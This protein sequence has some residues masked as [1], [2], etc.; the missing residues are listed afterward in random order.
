MIG[1]P[2]IYRWLIV[3][4]IVFGA[5]FYA[6]HLMMNAQPESLSALPVYGVQG[7]DQKDHTIKAF[8]LT[9]QFNN[10]VS[11]KDF[12]NKIYVADFIF[13]TCEGICPK[14][15]DQ[16]ERVYENFKGEQDVMFLSH[17]VKPEEDSIPVLKAYADM[18]H[19]TNDQWRFV[20]GDKKVIYDLA[21]S[22]YLV[23]DS[24]GAG[25]KDDFVHTQFF[26]LIDT[27][28]RIR[29]FYDGTDSVEVNK[30]I[31]DIDLLMNGR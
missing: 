14:M 9:D 31:G 18:H 2:V 30:L 29:G 13:T 4:V 19:V 26:V 10:P 3:S 27:K 1:K 28:K 16:M 23:A 17:T 20:R 25:G 15:S 7:A 24:I 6:Y 8:Q 11:Q 21:R 5:I 22:A 12:E